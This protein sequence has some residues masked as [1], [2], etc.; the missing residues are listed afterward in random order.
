MSTIYT[1]RGYLAQ[2]AFLK[3]RDLIFTDYV[4]RKKIHLMKGYGDK[5]QALMNGFKKGFDSRKAFVKDW[6]IEGDKIIIRLEEGASL[7]KE[8]TLDSIYT[9]LYSFDEEGVTNSWCKSLLMGYVS[10]EKQHFKDAE[11]IY[12]KE[13]SEKYTITVI[14]HNGDVL[15]VLS[16]SGQFETNVSAKEIPQKQFL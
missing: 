14:R 10:T 12:L 6:M 9:V 16:R 4:L 13:L 15:G 5:L 2:T 1:T 3:P 11:I 8:R 7:I